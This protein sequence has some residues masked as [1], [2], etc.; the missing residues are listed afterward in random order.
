[1]VIS[2]FYESFLLSK[3]GTLYEVKTIEAASPT[4]SIKNI[5]KTIHSARKKMRNKKGHLFRASTFMPSP[6]AIKLKSNENPDNFKTKYYKIIQKIKKSKFFALCTILNILLIYY[7]F[8]DLPISP[9]VYH[10]IN[11]VFSLIFIS[12]LILGVIFYGGFTYLKK[13]SIR[14]LDLFNFVLIFI[15]MIMKIW[16]FKTIF[17]GKESYLSPFIDT[18]KILQLFKIIRKSRIFFL[19]SMSKLMQEIV[20]SVINLWDFIAIISVV[21]LVCSFI[22]VELLKINFNDS[23]E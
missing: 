9:H 6:F 12:E 16:Y 7:E 11:T 10:N 23:I 21:L 2:E 18:L 20:Y 15:D 19:R 14:K 17:P 1:M 4:S 13:K 22:G 3:N 8:T 5:D